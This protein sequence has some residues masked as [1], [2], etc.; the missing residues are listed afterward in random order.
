MSL[1]SSLRLLLGHLRL[2]GCQ[3][4][5]SEKGFVDADTHLV[6]LRLQLVQVLVKTALDDFVHARERQVGAELAKQF[7]R[8]MPER[9][10][11]RSR[12]TV[13]RI[14]GRQQ[15]I[16]DRARESAIEQQEIQH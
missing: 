1:G 12:D 13:Q 15:A 9:A 5:E 2:S 7:F 8:R 4:L 3:G 14:A 10:E 16:M 11:G 6:D